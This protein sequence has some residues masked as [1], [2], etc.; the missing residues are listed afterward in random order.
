VPVPEL[1]ADES[2]G[3]TDTLRPDAGVI[4]PLKAAIALAK[5]ELSGLYSFLGGVMGAGDVVVDDMGGGA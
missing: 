2:I 5:G 3:S 4:S 1:D